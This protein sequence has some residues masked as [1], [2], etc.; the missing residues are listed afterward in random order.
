MARSG[1]AVR[2]FLSA[3]VLA[4]ASQVGAQA[5]KQG[6]VLNFVVGS[7]IPS[8]DLHRETTFGA[9]HPIRPFYSTLIRVNPEN[10][11]NSSEFVCDVCEGVVPQ[12]TENGTVYTF[13][14]KRGV[15]FH[16]GTEMTSA[17]VKASMDKIIFPPEGVRSARRS[18]F[19]MVESVDAPDNYTVVFRL[20]FPSGAFVPALATPFNVILSKQDLDTHG[21]DWHKRNIN[22]TGAFEF[23][24]HQPGAFVEGKRFDTFTGLVIHTSTA[25][26]PFPRPKWPYGSRP[27]AATV[28]PSSFAGSRPRRATTWSRH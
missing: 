6:G 10:P 27:Y 25:S 1:V 14:L 20:K 24:R 11:G 19:R 22:G 12:P 28:Q 23:V 2:A 5:P 4:L 26:N 17:D 21:Y 18:F 16:D 9:M 8:F 7:K 13:K 3:G 15:K